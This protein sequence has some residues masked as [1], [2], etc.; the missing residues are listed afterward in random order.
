MCS[1]DTSR[2]RDDTIEMWDAEAMGCIDEVQTKLRL[3]IV[4]NDW[5]S[6][7]EEAMGRLLLKGEGL[8]LL[9]HDTYIR[10]ASTKRKLEEF[11]DPAK[12]PKS[13]VEDQPEYDPTEKQDQVLPSGPESPK[14]RR[15]GRDKNGKRIAGDTAVESKLRL[16]KAQNLIGKGNIGKSSDY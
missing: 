12:R 9:A 2:G 8:G 11:Q 14:T 4:I 13:Q 1:I 15:R 16:R 5:A 7:M 6:S 3:P 10:L